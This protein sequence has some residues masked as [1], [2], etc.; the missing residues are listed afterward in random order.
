MKSKE[1]TDI[2][3]SGGV[4]VKTQRNLEPNEFDLLMETLTM[5]HQV[6]NIEDYIDG[7]TYIPS[8]EPKEKK[9][10]EKKEA[11]RSEEK[12]KEAVPVKEEAASKAEKAPEKA[13]EKVTEK[14]PEKAAPVKEAE[15]KP[16][17]PAKEAPAVKAEEPKAPAETTA[18]LSG[19]TTASRP[20]Q[21]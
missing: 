18:T 17:A 21:S 13:P 10:P 2:L 6:K 12:P 14:A 20:E 19:I 15:A 16:E 7:L 9:A 4:E 5:R 3:A 11:V 8:A 1:L